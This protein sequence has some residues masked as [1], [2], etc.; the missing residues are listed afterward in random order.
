MVRSAGRYVTKCCSH[1]IIKT[2]KKDVW[3]HD[4]DYAEN[5]YPITSSKYYVKV[6]SHS[7]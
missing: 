1:D 4:Y 6:N 5:V 2:A 7:I 3:T